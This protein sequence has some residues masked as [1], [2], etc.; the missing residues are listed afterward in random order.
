MPHVIVQNCCND[1]SCVPECPVDCIHPTPEEPGFATAEMLYID[2]DVCIDCGACIDACPVSAITTDYELTEEMAPFEE[3]NADYYRAVGSAADLDHPYTDPQLGR[4]RPPD[5]AET[6]RVAVVGAG[7]AGHYAVSELQNRIDVRCEIDVYERL[8]EPGGLVRFGV[9]PDH[10]S[11]KKVQEQFAAAR[12]RNDVSVHLGVAVGEDV[13]HEELA[14]THHAVIYAVGALHG[15]PLPLPGGGLPVVAAAADFVAWYNGH[16]DLAGRRFDLSHERVVVLGNGNVALDVA[17]VL[18]ADP[19]V[20]VGTDMSDEAVEALRASHVREVVVLA[21]RGPDHA[22]FTA[23]ELVGLARAV[24][25][26]VDPS[27]L[28]NLDAEPAD[29]QAAH[30]VR[31]KLALLRGLAGTSPA[32]GRRVVLRFGTRP[33]AITATDD[34]ASVAFDDHG[35]ESSLD[36]GQVLAAI[37]LRGT[38]VPGLPFDEAGGVIPN[39]DGRVLGD[40]GAPLPGVYASGWIKRGATG[41]IGTNRYDARGTVDAVVT[42]FHE[43]LLTAE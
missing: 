22:A 1:A 13:T 33:T 5:G 24:P 38:A 27:D 21:R 35:T 43:G 7:A 34:G 23:P 40:D 16:P 29:P 6:L 28:E 12:G 42:D 10:A 15:R 37:G 9:A 32:E 11:T 4:R 26:V 17:R 19:E 18:T 39:A 20:F 3:I 14:R 41:V 30:Y 31:Q 8:P 25:V 36:C 2:P